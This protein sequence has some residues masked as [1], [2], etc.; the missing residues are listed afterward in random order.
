MPVCCCFSSRDA[1]IGGSHA[2]NQADAIAEREMEEAAAAAAARELEMMQDEA[3]GGG[4]TS[5]DN[6]MA[7]GGDFTS[8]ESDRYGP[9]SSSAGVGVGAGAAKVVTGRPPAPGYG[10]NFFA[11]SEEV[12][13][14]FCC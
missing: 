2:P 4:A 3:A 13:T 7:F 8:E 14:V 5:F 9:P 6:E 1:H 10:R 12:R 11:E